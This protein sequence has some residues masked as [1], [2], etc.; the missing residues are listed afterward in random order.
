MLSNL[1]AKGRIWILLIAWILFTGLCVVDMFDLSDD[2]VLPTAL[3]Q[4]AVAPASTDDPKPHVFVL[5]VFPYGGEFDPLSLT[6]DRDGSPWFSMPF[7]H[8]DTPL[9]QRHSVYRI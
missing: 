2:I 7:T 8:R 9:Y 4:L 3:G 5:K 1:N 6:G